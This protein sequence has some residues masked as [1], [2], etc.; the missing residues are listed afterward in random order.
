M[1]W[2]F[3]LLY[4]IYSWFTTIGWMCRRKIPYFFLVGE[5]GKQHPLN[6]SNIEKY[7]HL[8]VIYY[9]PAGTRYRFHPLQK[10]NMYN[11]VGLL[12]RIYRSFEEPKKQKLYAVNA[13][14]QERVHTIN[15][16]EFNIVGNEIFSR[17]FNLW[18]CYNYL[19][20]APSEHV[21][22]S[23]IDD[24]TSIR[25]TNGPIR[26]DDDGIKLPCI[27]EKAESEQPLTIIPE[28]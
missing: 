9:T 15:A 22:V 14:I 5:D 17:T 26:F 7:N 8:L 19:H 23:Y 21:E 24:T 3:Y 18:L 6:E 25:V 28:E 11:T 20:I 16:I 10:V 2:F 13:T 1:D 4:S 27:A 12:K